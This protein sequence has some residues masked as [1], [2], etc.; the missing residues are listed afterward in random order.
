MMQIP[1][2]PFALLLTVLAGIL[3]LA[4]AA[5]GIYF[6]V[7]FLASPFRCRNA[8]P[9]EEPSTR[10]AVLVPARNEEKVIRRVLSSLA[11]M[12]Y[13]ADLVD[14][15]VIADNCTDS[16][17]LLA[18][19]EGVAVLERQDPDRRSK[20]QA[21]EWAFYEKGLLD[22]GYDA[23]CIIDAD[24]TVAPDFLR[25]I[26]R[27]IRAGHSVVQGRC[28]SLNPHVSLTSSLTAIL[29]I[30]GNRFWNL[31]LSN[32]GVSVLN[33]GTGVAFRQDHLQRV[34][35]KVRTLVEDTE[36]ALQTILSGNEVHYCDEAEYRVEQ[37]TDVPT[38][39]RQQRRWQ[40]GTFECGRLYFADLIHRAF[41]E[42]DAS[43]WTGV[44]K[45]LLSYFCI[46]GL[47]QWVL[48]P[49]VT[50]V[51]LGPQVVT[52]ALALAW[53]LGFL[54]SGMVQAT[55]ILW[56]DGQLRLEMWRGIALFAL[57]PVF[58]GAVCLAS[59][60]RPKKRWETI[61][62]GKVDAI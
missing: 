42:R 58:L 18:A 35:W 9:L 4:Q 62:H 37:A 12:D 59:L 23:F 25:H 55:L 31:P 26:E 24:N 3:T 13:P 57:Y 2:A 29:F 53:V 39:W 40:S 11:S 6:T 56:F 19:A 48:G 14:V 46:L 47:I 34:G 51:V 32:R 21:M 15:V 33:Y 27:A 30:L 1:L 8:I 49:L 45:I 50:L 61:D 52:P 20:S 60:L 17:A 41:K 7:V 43:A 44:V 10:F 38:L 28:E 54:L 5:I 22:A 36:F 16:T